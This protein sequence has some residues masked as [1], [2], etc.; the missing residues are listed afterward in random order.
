MGKIIAIFQIAHKVPNAT[1]Y[2]SSLFCKIITCCNLNIYNYAGEL[3]KSIFE[4]LKDDPFKYSELLSVFEKLMSLNKENMFM[5]E[6]IASNLQS[7]CSLFNKYLEGKWQN[8]EF[9]THFLKLL[10]TIYSS[11]KTE[12]LAQPAFAHISEK[13]LTIFLE[14]NSYEARRD[15]LKF[16]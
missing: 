12:L 2:F 9:L 11:S 15:I 4:V 7:I 10:A 6:Y 13:L 14:Y 8:S 16:W 1:G 5:R 3:I